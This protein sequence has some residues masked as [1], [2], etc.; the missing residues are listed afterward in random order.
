MPLLPNATVGTPVLI[1]GRPLK[2]SFWPVYKGTK[3][4]GLQSNLFVVD[5]WAV[6][7][8]RIRITCPPAARAEALASL[9]QANDFY[10]SS[11]TSSVAAA[12]PLQTYYCFMNLVK[13]LLLTHGTRPTFNKAMHGLSEQ[14]S[15]GNQELR[16]AY[17]DAYPS[18]NSKGIPQIFGEFYKYLRG[19]NVP[20]NSN[21]L[22]PVLL[23][24]ILPGHRLW[25]DA[26]NKQER[27]I[28]IHEIRVMQSS[29]PKRLWV[30]IFF[31]A[32]DLTRLGITHK[33][34]L[35]EAQLDQSFH[36]VK[37]IETSDGRH[38]LCFEQNHKTAFTQRPADKLQSV[39]DLVK[40]HLWVSVN[41]AQPY[42]RY[43]VY[44]APNTEHSQ[45][46]PQLLSVFSI[47]YY[48][49]SIT[50]YRPQHFD[51][52]LASTFGPRI[53]EFITVQPLQFVYLVAS[54]FARQEITKPAL[55]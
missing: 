42:R 22:L 2:F 41:G 51:K 28:S 27:F 12:R 45:V 14:L 15:A 50:R 26:A 43:Y 1:K 29:S 49:G 17:L 44:A 19:Q 33:R 47:A 54:E 24:Q 9:E 3:R 38:L 36:E 4:A 6:M 23:P 20:N 32:D 34:L 52:I 7:R 31:A 55:I 11:Q 48:L 35:A 10:T 16:D 53:E 5:P 40:R 39:I 30:N 46:L 8:D 21:Y 25:A 13:A 18:P 37:C